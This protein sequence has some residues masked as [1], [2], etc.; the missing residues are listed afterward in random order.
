ME[1]KN[2]VNSD[3]IRDILI[4]VAQRFPLSSG[5]GGS[6]SFTINEHEGETVL[7]LT[8]VRETPTG[9][10]F[11]PVRFDNEMITDKNLDDIGAQ[12]KQ[13]ELELMAEEAGKEPQG[14]TQQM[15]TQKC[16]VCDI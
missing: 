7:N 10:K 8:I 13:R 9:L 6:H 15:E 11:W 1:I 2:E 12:L 4:A 16:K 5:F 3:A 14:V